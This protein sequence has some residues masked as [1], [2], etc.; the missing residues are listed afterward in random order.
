MLF[1]GVN[2]S[3]SHLKMQMSKMS[4]MAHSPGWKFNALCWL[5]VQFGLWRSILYVVSACFFF[6][7]S[8]FIFN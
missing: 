7:L 3:C 4:R 2:Q 1:Y 8:L 6:F 5:E